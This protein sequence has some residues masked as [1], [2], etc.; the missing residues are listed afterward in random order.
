MNK[1]SVVQVESFSGMVNLGKSKRLNEMMAANRKPVK[2]VEIKKKNLTELEQ[3]RC[4]IKQKIDEIKAAYPEGKRNSLFALR[5]T[6]EQKIAKMTIGEVFELLKL[7][8]GQFKKSLLSAYY[9]AN[10]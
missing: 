5:Y 3:A 8:K 2:S 9:S 6:S 4:L 1:K 7:N 10:L